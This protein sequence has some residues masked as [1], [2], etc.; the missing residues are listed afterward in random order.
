MGGTCTVGKKQFL[1]HSCVIAKVQEAA[2]SFNFTH[3]QTGS[4]SIFLESSFGP[5]TD[6]GKNLH[7]G[8]KIIVLFRCQG[9]KFPVYSE[10]NHFIVFPTTLS[11]GKKHPFWKSS[12]TDVGVITIMS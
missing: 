12:V 10:S 6:F 1:F 11:T 3:F 8:R 7:V 4:R 9:E 5:Y 2:I